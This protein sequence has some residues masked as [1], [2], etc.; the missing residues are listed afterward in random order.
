MT[1]H[2]LIRSNPSMSSIGPSFSFLCFVNLDMTD[3]ELLDLKIFD[4]CVGFEILE[5][6]E[7]N[8]A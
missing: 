8:F 4:L 1:W 2:G 3:E 6:P 5:K 7:E